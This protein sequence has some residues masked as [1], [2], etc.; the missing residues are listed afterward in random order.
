MKI[1]TSFFYIKIDIL[2]TLVM[3]IFLLSDKFRNFISSFF[4][5]Y[6]FIFF[7]ELSHIFVASLFGKEVDTLTLSLFGVNVL[8]ISKHYDTSLEINN[9]NIKEIIIYLAGP[10]SNFLL[11]M[12]FFNIK[13]VFEI[14]IFLGMLNLI[15]I[16]PLDGYNIIRELLVK[17]KYKYKII[18]VT[19]NLLI[20]ILFLIGIIIFIN[21]YNASI[22][23]FLI[24]LIILRK[25][26]QSILNKQNI[27]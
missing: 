18:K 10:I 15:P 23:L 3:F 27:A 14:N 8:F 13:F 21:N 4:I 24:Y 19:S 11:G 17:N 22:I 1:K 5:C 12:L 25:S 26:S 7:H 2:F 9:Y 16:Y 20:I 6:L